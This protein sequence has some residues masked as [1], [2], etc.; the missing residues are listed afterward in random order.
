M[1]L[2]MAASAT[3]A[4]PAAVSAAEPVELTIWVHETD[5][6]DEGKLY[7][8][9]VDEFNTQY[10]GQYHATISPDCKKRRCGRI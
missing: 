5:A 9:L 2:A 1:T 3:C 4:V 6:T 8:A 7:A 10:E